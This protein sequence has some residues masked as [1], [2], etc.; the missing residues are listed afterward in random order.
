MP[1]TADSLA[2]HLLFAMGPE[3]VRSVMI[4]GRWCLKDRA[5]VTCDEAAIRARS[6]E[7]SRHLHE[8]ITK[9]P[10]PTGRLIHDVQEAREEF[11]AG[12]ARSASVKDIMDEVG[13]ES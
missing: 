10:L 4:A 7:V 1:L 8:R 12:R 6:V 9:I 5:V 11:A 13:G 3:Y 2:S